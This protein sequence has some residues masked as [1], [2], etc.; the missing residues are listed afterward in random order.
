MFF[1]AVCQACARPGLADAFSS[2]RP[3]LPTYL[4]NLVPVRRRVPVGHQADTRSGIPD[5]PRADLHSRNRTPWLPYPRQHVNNN[6]L[7]S[8]SKWTLWPARCSQPS[9][10]TLP[11]YLSFLSLCCPSRI[12]RQDTNYQVMTTTLGVDGGRYLGTPINPLPW[13]RRSFFIHETGVVEDRLRR[14]SCRRDTP[15]TRH[16]SVVD[17]GNRPSW[18]PQRRQTHA[19]DCPTRCSEVWWCLPYSVF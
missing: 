8:R 3:Q 17:L 10:S 18:K 7:Q 6:N 2:H 9:G 1:S 14:D 4:C 12:K 5:W 11:M 15:E 16:G 13:H 19:G